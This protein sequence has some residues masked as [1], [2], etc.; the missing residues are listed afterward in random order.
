MGCRRVAD[1]T[2]LVGSPATGRTAARRPAGAGP[3]AWLCCPRRT[4]LPRRGAAAAE[5]STGRCAVRVTD[6]DVDRAPCETVRSRPAWAAAAAA[7]EPGSV[8]TDLALATKKIRVYELAREL[9][10]ENQVVLDLADELKIGREEP[11]LEHRGPVGRPRPPPGRHRGLRGEPSV[12]EPKPKPAETTGRPRSGQ[13]QPPEPEPVVA[14]AASRHRRAE[15]SWPSREPVRPAI[16][17][18]ARPAGSPRRP[19]P[20]C[21]RRR[22][23]PRPGPPRRPAAPAAAATA[24]PA[25]P[26]DRSGAAPRRRRQPVAQLRPASRSRPRP[27]QRLT[28]PPPGQ[29]A[30]FA[31]GPCDRRSAARWRRRPVASRQRSVPVAVVPAAARWLPVAAVPVAAPGGPGGGGGPGGFTR[32]SSG[33]Q[34]QRP[35]RKKRRRRDF[36]D[37]GPQSATALTPARRARPRGR[38]RRSR[39]ASRS[40]SSRPSSTA[41]RADLVRILFDAGE[42]V[43]GTQS[44]ADEMIELIARD[45][46]RRGA[47]RRARPGGRAR[48]AG[49]ARRRRDDEDEALLEPRPPIVTVM[50]HVDHGKTTLLDAIR[51]GERRRGRGRRHHAAHR[52]L[53]GRSTNDRPITFIDT[54]GHEA[55]TAMRAR[56]ARGDR[57][58]GARRR[59]RRRRHAPDDRGDQPR[60]RRRGAD[61]RGDHQGRP[62]GRRHRPGS[63]QQLVEQ[64][65]VPE[66]WGGDTIVIEV[67]APTGPRH[68]RAAR[69]DPAR[70]RR[71]RP[72]ARREPEGAG[73]RV[74]ARVEPRPGP[75]PRRH[76][77][78]RSGARCASATR[79]SPVAA[80]ARSGPCST[81][82]GQAGQRSRPV[83]CRSRCSASTTC[84]SPAT[85]SGSR[86]TRRSPAPSPRP[87]RTAAAPRASPTR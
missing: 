70:R 20:P 31:P 14:A 87:A 8:R 63:R 44:L 50:G 43:T 81:K 22:C 51:D 23:P 15:P 76:R 12:D 74:R 37:L 21:R 7:A 5:R 16:A 67:A 49:A 45:A 3:G 75:R 38:D 85:S 69:G 54:P 41:P 39:A 64:Q 68:R 60:P 65:L 72:A 77:A 71:R 35:R 18:S 58:R 9:G 66:E 25:A 19:P 33:P 61:R 56:G 79:S 36:E 40:R 59:R 82:H 80:G 32:A 42:M 27:G 48:A 30:P 46:R 24:A 17:S 47:A 26:A 84:R 4:G 78:R 55:F 11:L 13:A 34:G 6:T 10:V 62:R 2:A 52:R 29:R 28:P 73:P 86:R 53:P 1:P 83:D 57:H